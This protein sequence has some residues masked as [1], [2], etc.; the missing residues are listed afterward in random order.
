[1]LIVIAAKQEYR[2][3][4]QLL[5]IIAEF[6]SSDIISG[7]CNIVRLKLKYRIPVPTLPSVWVAVSCTVT[8]LATIFSKP[9]VSHQAAITV[10][11]GNTGFA[12]TETSFGVTLP[13]S[14]QCFIYGANCI[15]G[16]FCNMYDYQSYNTDYYTSCKPNKKTNKTAATSNIVEI[17]ILIAQCRSQLNI[18]I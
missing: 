14:V 3:W 13:T 12:V 7:I 9:P 1:M 5:Q 16:T 4:L 10:W 18:Y 6:K 8:W 11:A 17:L 2:N 15:T